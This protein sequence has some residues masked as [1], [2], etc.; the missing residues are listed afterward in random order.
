MSTYYRVTKHPVTGIPEDALWMDDYYGH[1]EYGV[2][3][4]D[5]S[6]YRPEDVEKNKD[7]PGRSQTIIKTHSNKVILNCHSKKAAEALFV[8]LQENNPW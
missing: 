5:G 4:G 1:H 7:V 6:V 2:K 8:Y 3:F